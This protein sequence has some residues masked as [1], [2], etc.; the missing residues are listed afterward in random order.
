MTNQKIKLEK[1]FDICTKTAL[2]AIE[3]AKTGDATAARH[4]VLAGFYSGKAYQTAQILA[5]DYGCTE[6]TERRNELI[7]LLDALW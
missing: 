1:S 2:A 4:L 5:R 3:R 6:Y 7:A